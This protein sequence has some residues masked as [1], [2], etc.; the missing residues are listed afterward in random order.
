MWMRLM[1]S[2]S[3]SAMESDLNFG[4]SASLSAVGMLFVVITCSSCEALIRAMAGPERT[5][6]VQV[7]ETDFAPLACSAST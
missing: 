5:A 4:H 7:A 2:A 3:S 6:C 1:A